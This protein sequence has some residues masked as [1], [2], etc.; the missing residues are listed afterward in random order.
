ME[1]IAFNA[2]MAV[3]L[4]ILALTVGLFVF[5]TVRTDVAGLCILLVLG[6]SSRVPGVGPLLPPEL[7][8]SGFSSNAVI[9]IIAVM[10]IGAGLDRS[11]VMMRVANG[12]LV[13]GGRSEIKLLVLVCAATAT[14]SLF[15][16]NVAAAALF[17]PVVSRI[18]H[19]SG[20]PVA[21]LMM[22][23][24]FCAI[25]GGLGTMVGSSSMIVLNDLIE[26]STARLPDGGPI[27]SYPLF[28]VLPLGIAMTG[29]CIG[30]FAVLA[31]FRRD[32]EVAAPRESRVS[33]YVERVYGIRGEL[34]EARVG[35]DSTLAGR[36]VRALEEN[37]EDAPFLLAMYSGDVVK[38]PPDPEETIWVNSRLGLMGDRDLIDRFCRAHDLEQLEP[39]RL[40]RVL[41]PQQSG[42]AE[43]VVPPSSNLVGR[44]IGTIKPRRTFGVNILQIARR[45]EVQLRGFGD[46]VLQ[47]GDTLLAHA[48]WADFEKLKRTNRN[49]VVATDFRYEQVRVE[50]QRSAIGLFIASLLLFFLT[51]EMSLS[52]MAGAIAMVLVG[53]VS[54]DE[55]YKAVS[56]STIFLLASLIPLGIAV[57]RTGTATWLAQNALRTVGEVSPWIIQ[58]VLA[59]IATAFSLL[60]SNVGATVLLVPLAINIALATGAEPALFALTVAVATSNAFLIPTNQVNAL[61][62]GPGGYRVADFLRVGGGMTAIYLVGS[63]TV[64]NLLFA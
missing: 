35:Q 11:G 13:R 8:F 47:A 51:D 15:V 41:D 46:T 53:V 23:M 24:G 38:V 61:I 7:L 32:G 9:A 57:D 60:M 49:V 42:I 21:R 5:D 25:L 30:Y 62:A 10:I 16:Q 48:S 37:F 22:P 54:I 27:A 6:L 2:D 12:I 39:D 40:A 55:A 45:G 17:L 33:E 44:A 34:I 14:L 43:L 4:G 59:I 31:R 52:L 29:L 63:L 64:L 56:W 19:R 1:T 36:R 3:V 20:I 26:S 58:A 18:C 50:R 28:S